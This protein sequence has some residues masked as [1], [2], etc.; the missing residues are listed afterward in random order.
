MK[1]IRYVFLSGYF[2]AP[3]YFNPPR[4]RTPPETIGTQFSQTA[5]P[6]KYRSV[7]TWPATSG[8]NSPPLSV[9]WMVRM[10][11]MRFA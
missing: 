4:T 6:L 3:A 9:D 2:A 8:D 11:A 5:S 7:P 1:G 10:A